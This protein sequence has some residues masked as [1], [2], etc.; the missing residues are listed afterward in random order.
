[1]AKAA[2]KPQ[3]KHAERMVLP[4]SSQTACEH[5]LGYVGVEKKNAEEVWF[6]IFI[7]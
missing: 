5:A 3:I 7:W 4:S 6:I 2:T 1:M